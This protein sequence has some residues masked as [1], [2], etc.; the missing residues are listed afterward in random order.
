MC[1]VK[2]YKNPFKLAERIPRCLFCEN[3]KTSW[4]KALTKVLKTDKTC[5]TAVYWRTAIMLPFYI[6]L[7]I[8]LSYNVK[9]MWQ[10]P[11]SLLKI[12]YIH[13]RTHAHTLMHASTHIH[14]RLMC[15]SKHFTKLLRYLMCTWFIL[16]LGW[17][18]STFWDFLNR[19]SK[20]VV[21]NRPLTYFLF[22]F[23]T[24]LLS[25]LLSLN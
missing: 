17:P 15:C 12:T 21:E 1:K 3:Y 23:H 22:L 11:C 8:T 14:I 16:A 5:I 7:H 18:T 4:D 6:G 13:A 10:T 20:I 9:T 25:F 2:V 19:S 24:T